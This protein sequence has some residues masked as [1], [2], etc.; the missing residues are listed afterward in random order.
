[1]KGVPQSSLGSQDLYIMAFIV[2]EDS[3]V[4]QNSIVGDLVERGGSSRGI[5]P[6]RE[7]TIVQT[8]KNAHCDELVRQKR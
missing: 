5:C 8:C 6:T 4:T 1:M 3:E 7:D 2:V